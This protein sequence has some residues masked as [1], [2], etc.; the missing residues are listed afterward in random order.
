MKKAT[1]IEQDYDM[2]WGT[3][4]MLGIALLIAGV[5]AISMPF[6]IT[7]SIQL[8]LGW[9]LVIIGFIQLIMSFWAIKQ[10]R[11]LLTIGTGGLFIILGLLL[12]YNPYATIIAATSLIGIFFLIEGILKV[13]ISTELK[14]D[15]SWRWIMFGGIISI[16]FAF[17][18]LLNV[19]TSSL[20]VIG[21]L[22]GVNALFSGA[23]HVTNSLITRSNGDEDKARG[24]I[25]WSMVITFLVIFTVF[26]FI[27]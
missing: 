20:F 14:P 2:S 11:F 18:I 17:M 4:L 10:G 19:L 21:L 13:V 7:V 6:M 26:G 5:V 25:V 24:A 3:Q 8:V 1:M 16:I 9:L 15:P 27:A 22:I 12:I 23:A